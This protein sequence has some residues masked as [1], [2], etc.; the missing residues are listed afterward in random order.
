M[1]ITKTTKYHFMFMRLAMI[2]KSENKALARMEIN[3][4]F[5]NVPMDA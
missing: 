2:N 4:K 5:Y 3:G 1:Q